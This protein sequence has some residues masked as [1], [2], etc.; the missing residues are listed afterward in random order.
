ML[1]E[2]HAHLDFPEYKEDLDAVI[3]RAKSSNIGIIINVA[4]SIEGSFNSVELSNR[5]ESIYACCGVH[6]HD[7]KEVDDEVIDRLRQLVSSSEKVV[8]I[9]EIGLDFYRNLSPKESQYTVFVKFLK[10]AREL[11]LPIILHCREESQDTRSAQDMLFKAME[12]NLD[13]PFRG[14]L[15]CFS[16]D[17]EFLKKAIG[18]GLYVSFTCNITY[19]KADRLRQVLKKVPLDRL[20]LETDSPFLAPQQK[21][22]Q[23]NEP[24]YLAHLVDAICQNNSIEKEELERQTTQNAK[25]LFS[26]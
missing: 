15:H 11:D 5:Y 2:T 16:G 25:H 21:R 20:L 7:A 17:E 26:I 1:I 3:E 13:K 10:L 24:A 19:K 9:G 22:G 8:A 14:V 23:R 4:S 6:P 18:S 12:E